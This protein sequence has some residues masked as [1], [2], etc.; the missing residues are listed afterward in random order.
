MSAAA[1]ESVTTHF[2]QFND[3][4]KRQRDVDA[5]PAQSGPGKFARTADGGARQRYA[6][7]PPDLEKLADK[8]VIEP[9]VVLANN[10]N[11]NSDP[12]YTRTSVADVTLDDSPVV[13]DFAP[14]KIMFGIAYYDSQSM[15]SVYVKSVDELPDNIRSVT[16][17]LSLTDARNF[18]DSN[19]AKL[20][21]FCDAVNQKLAEATV[22]YEWIKAPR[23]KPALTPEKVLEDYIRPMYSGSIN[24]PPTYV[25]NDG[26]ERTNE[27]VLYTKAYINVDDNTGE[28]FLSTQVYDRT[29]LVQTGTY[30]SAKRID[31]FDNLRA[32]KV[33]LYRLR[34]AGVQLSAGPKIGVSWKMERATV[35]EY[36]P[37]ESL[38]DA[39]TP[40]M[41]QLSW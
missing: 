36:V 9:P 17:R 23:G 33:G 19:E 11:K 32:N 31:A 5:A 10:N 2:S 29:S 3:N 38:A 1:V 6:F 30:G 35:D 13:L 24:D 21:R 28:R 40:N 25:N 14:G 22:K 26:D 15:R 27:I 18:P 39:E 8:I 41:D 34:L 4:K 7:T 20:M 12:K 16:I 37:R